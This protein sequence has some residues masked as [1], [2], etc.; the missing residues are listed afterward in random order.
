MKKI[1]ISLITSII[2]ILNSFMPILFILLMYANSGLLALLLPHDI[3]TFTLIIANAV[4]SFLMFIIFYFSKTTFAKIASI[5]GILLFFIPFL[6][7]STEDIFNDNLYYFLTFLIPSVITSI[8]LITI[9]TIQ[10][11]LAKNSTPHPS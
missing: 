7:Y 8:L 1:K 11:K 2:L 3:S 10:Q 4:L 5:F 6:L 9:E